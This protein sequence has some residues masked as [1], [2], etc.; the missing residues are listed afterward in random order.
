M[1]KR[2]V[3]AAVPSKLVKEEVEPKKELPTAAASTAPRPQK[4]AKT[5]KPAAPSKE[6]L[7]NSKA[8]ELAATVW[9]KDRLKKVVAAIKKHKTMAPTGRTFKTCWPFEKPVDA[10]VFTDYYTIIRQPIHIEEIEKKV[11]SCAYGTVMT[12]V[13]DIRLL[14]SNAF[15]YNEGQAGIEVRLLADTV[16]EVAVA[17]CRRVLHEAADSEDENKTLLSF[18]AC[19]SDYTFYDDSYS[20]NDAD[21][22]LHSQEPVNVTEFVEANPLPP[23]P[24]TEI[25]MP[26]NDSAVG[27]K[28]SSSAPTVKVVKVQTAVYADDEEEEEENRPRFYDEG[29]D[30]ADDYKM[31]EDGNDDDDDDDDEGMDGITR[32]ELVELGIKKRGRSDANS[33]D[34]DFGR[35]AQKGKSKKGKSGSKVSIKKGGLQKRKSEYDNDDEETV[36]Y[37]AAEPQE[38]FLSQLLLMEDPKYELKD[39]ELMCCQFLRRLYKHPYVSGDTNK[40]ICDFTKPIVAQYPHIQDQYEEKIARPMDLSIVRHNIALGGVFR[41][42]NYFFQ[43]VRQYFH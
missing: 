15:T 36:A 31:E 32:E 43:D 5:I 10:N 26:S 37:V 16:M 40:R 20:W 21:S 35:R 4:T 38:S 12:F 41:D 25:V 3:R 23:A 17:F 24:I 27:K 13:N 7:M 29:D 6:S 33:D 9:L 28:K 39:W 18:G 19:T 8:R 1:M 2:P 22:M 42:C 14:R 11:S 34:D 30:P